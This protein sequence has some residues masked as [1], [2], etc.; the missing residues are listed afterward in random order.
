MNTDADILI[1][2][3]GQTLLE[4]GHYPPRLNISK[5]P[6]LVL[7]LLLLEALSLPMCSESPKEQHEVS[8]LTG[9]G[10]L[11]GKRQEKPEG[12]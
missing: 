6:E 12:L 3:L 1:L 2:A 10:W 4:P 7:G 8:W 11:A 9:T 5:E